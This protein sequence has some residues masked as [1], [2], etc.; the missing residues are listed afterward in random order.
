MVW[1]L[2]PQWGGRRT[3]VVALPEETSSATRN[4]I[5]TAVVVA[6]C[7]CGRA[8]QALAKINIGDVLDSDGNCAGALSAFEEGYGKTLK[9]I[10]IARE[11]HDEAKKFSHQTGVKVVVAYGGA[12][13]SQ[14][15]R[16]L[17]RGVGIL[18]ATP[19]RLVDMIER[20]RVSLRTIKYLALD[21]A[22]RMLDMGFEPQIRR[23]V[24]QMEMPPPGTRQTMLFS[25]TFPTEIQRLASDFMSNYI[26]LAVGR[27]GSSTDLI[28]QKV[29][30][31]QDM[32]KR[33]YLMDLLHT[34][35]DNGAHG[36]VNCIVAVVSPLLDN[37]QL[38]WLIYLTN[39]TLLFVMQCALTL[40]FVETKRGADALERWLSMN[41]FP[42]TAIHGDKVQMFNS[43]DY[44][45]SSSYADAVAVADSNAATS[46]AF[47]YNTP[48]T[49]DYAAA[50]VVDSYATHS[51]GFAFD[52][53][54]IVASG[55]D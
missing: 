19:G 8:G 9:S 53:E 38:I 21:E 20:A 32:D 2:L 10:S 11:I 7:G 50:G 45:Y 55:W 3:M 47:T 14:Q 27:V 44:N 49:I 18:V 29:E 15:L 30:F 31:V 34:Q 5:K 16:N 40:T 17:E 4:R 42:T 33:N 46:N 24:E 6:T 52:Q 23:I 39:A 35:C 12:P 36:K 26:F 37:R 22:D 13:I 41:G 43:G 51:R 25:A 1:R 48:I 28:V 54:P